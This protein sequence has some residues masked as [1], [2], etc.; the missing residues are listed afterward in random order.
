MQG[1]NSGT[2]CLQIGGFPV[3]LRKQ[4][5]K[6]AIRGPF[7]CK[8]EDLL[9]SQKQCKGAIQGPLA[10]KYEDFLFSSENNVRMQC[11]N[12][13]LERDVRLPACARGNA[14]TPCLRNNNARMVCS[15]KLQESG[16]LPC[17]SALSICHN[18]SVVPIC[19]SISV[20]LHA[21]A[22]AAAS[23]VH[24]SAAVT[25]K[26]SVVLEMLCL[27]S[28]DYCALS[29]VFAP[30]PCSNAGMALGRAVKHCTRTHWWPWNLCPTSSSSHSRNPIPPGI[31]GGKEDG[32]RGSKVD[33]RR[34]CRPKDKMEW[35]RTMRS[36]ASRALEGKGPRQASSLGSHLKVPRPSLS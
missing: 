8:Y 7:A 3:F 21:A 33:G 2:P 31:E 6:D 28:C 14:R 19:S 13:L 5:N 17:T 9:F 27:C 15:N 29:S 34:P 18:F 24:P 1:C 10:C 30:S 16:S 20:W 12:L 35:R 36:K 23:A 25:R 11:K 22:A 4:Y 32:G 26:G